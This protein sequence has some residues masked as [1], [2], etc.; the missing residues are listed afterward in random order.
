MRAE[1][2]SAN[3]NR[4]PSLR[5]LLLGQLPRGYD[6]GAQPCASGKCQDV[7]LV[8]GG[9]EEQQHPPTGTKSLWYVGEGPTGGGVISSVIACSATSRGAN[10]RN[11]GSMI[12]RSK[13]PVTLANTSLTA[14]S[15]RTPLCLALY[16]RRGHGERVDVHARHFGDASRG[17]DGVHPGTGAHVEH[18]VLGVHLFEDRVTQ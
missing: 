14:K 17:Q 1:S 6:H 13:S 4:R 7:V 16:P 18:S 3:P 15:A 8:A 9:A 11:G 10:Q 5:W 12:M 2:R